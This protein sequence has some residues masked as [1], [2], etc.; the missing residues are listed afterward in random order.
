[1]LGPATT[2]PA[3]VAPDQQGTVVDLSTDFQ[4]DWVVLW[5]YPK[6]LTPG[7]TSC[8]KAFQQALYEFGAAGAVIIG[9]SFDSVE[10]NRSFLKENNFEFPLLSATREDGARW[11]VLR[12]E[13]DEWGAYPKRIS[14]L[15]D[16]NG[17]IVKSYKVGEPSQHPHEVL[18][19]LRVLRGEPE[20]KRRRGL[21]ERLVPS[22][23][24]SR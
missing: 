15:I 7:C 10:D 3:L 6:A 2:A 17:V 11:E 5:W 8:G 4:G 16:P 1:M 24:G 20:K 22:L 9:A 23:G 21:I 18:A 14:Y 19:D 13:D 12:A